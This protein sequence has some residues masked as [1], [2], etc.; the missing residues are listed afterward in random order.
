LRSIGAAIIVLFVF[1]AGI[2]VGYKKASF[3]HRWGDN[4]H[5]A[6]GER[7]HKGAFYKG[8]FQKDFSVAHGA[9]GKIIN[10]SL[11]SITIE[12]SDNTEKIALIS[13]KTFVRRFRETINPTDLKID[14]FAVVIGSPDD[15]GRI[16]ARLIR[17]MPSPLK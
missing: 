1:Q 17:I 9:V 5:R 13:D 7:R 4:Y 2:F 3:S 12:D 11:P 14:D 6:F 10:I 16:E 15:Q 8:D